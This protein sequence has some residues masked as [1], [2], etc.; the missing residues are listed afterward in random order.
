MV[1]VNRDEIP[2]SDVACES[3]DV[4]ED[5]TVGGNL[6]VG[7]T[8][9]GSTSLPFVDL[10]VSPWFVTPG[11]AS[12]AVRAAN[13]AAINAAIALYSGTKACLALPMG[14]IYIDQANGTDN[15]C[16]TFANRTDITLRGW[17]MFATRLIQQGPGDG[18][19]TYAVLVDNAQRIELCH[20]GI[21]QGTIDNPDPGQQNHL[22]AYLATNAAPLC[23]DNIIHDVYF[24]KAIGDQ[25][26]FIGVASQVTNTQ[27]YTLLFKGA[28]V[29]N[30]PSGRTG[31]RSCIAIQRGI[32][33]LQI[34]DFYADGAQNSVIDC[35]PS[36]AT[37]IRAVSISDFIAN[38]SLGSSEVAISFGGATGNIMTQGQ[39]TDFVVIGGQITVADLTDGVIGPFTMVSDAPYAG[40]PLAPSL[41]LINTITDVVIRDAIIERKGTSGIASLVQA[42]SGTYTRLSLKG[43]YYNQET[44]ADPLLFDKVESLNVSDV[45]V[46]YNGGTPAGRRAVAIKAVAANSSAPRVSN[47][48]VISPG[49]KMRAAVEYIARTPRTLLNI[50]TSN[51][52]CA[53]QVVRGVWYSAGAGSTMDTTPHMVG[54]DAGT[55]PAWKQADQSDNP[56][57]TIFPQVAGNQAAA[58]GATGDVTFASYVGAVAPEGVLSLSVGSEYLYLQQTGAPSTASKWRKQSQA[59]AGVADATGWR[60]VG[61]SVISPAAIGAGPTNNYAPANVDGAE[62]IRQATS[63]PAVVTGIA[64]SAAARGEGR[65]LIV[66]NISANTLTLNHEDA[67]SLAANRFSLPG[68]VALVIPANGSASLRYDSASSRWRVV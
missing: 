52:Q 40:S 56:I 55:D 5:L 27:A 14:D 25:L 49:G 59:A 50:S 28:G 53:G 21:Q 7:G 31:A 18:G 32:D 34:R 16:I 13:T 2:G 33:Q 38:Q 61:G 60:F 4:R 23:A 68:A 58:N 67:A 42:D 46:R 51:I 62:Q 12:D 48:Q 64:V 30:V 29:V 8:I 26:R 54:V 3:L 57:T 11:D 10:G 63:A 9:I 19:T 1:T 6:T 22:V 37:A 41:K 35:E 44:Q 45:V 20:F 47:L 65:S 43:G 36:G 39:L 17:G 24:G 15:W 66:T